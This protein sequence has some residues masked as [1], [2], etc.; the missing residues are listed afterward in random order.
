[1]R[2]ASPYW[3]I[4]LS[5]IPIL[6]LFYIRAARKRE[7]SIGKF[8]SSML[9]SSLVSAP[10]GR[11]RW[12]SY[13]FTLAGLFLI[14]IA[15]AMP[16]FGQKPADMERKGLDIEFVI[17]ASY[18]MAVSDVIANRFEYAKAAVSGIMKNLKGDRVGLTMFTN[19]TLGVVHLP[20]ITAQLNIS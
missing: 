12:T 19:S 16:Q 6:F 1:M 5:L 18:S 14:I 15:L 10:S 4:F 9:R 7:E 2:L 3:L 11:R 8:A 17:D 13:I 20:P